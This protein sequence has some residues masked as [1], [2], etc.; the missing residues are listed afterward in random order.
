M[1]M[2]VPIQRAAIG[3]DTLPTV[4]ARDLYA[5]LKVSRDFSTWIKDRIEK[6][7]FI[8]HEDYVTSEGLSSPNPGSAKARAQRTIDYHLTL[9]MAKELS[10][11]ENNAQGRKARRYFIDVERRAQ[12]PATPARKPFPS[13]LTP[14]QFRAEQQR[15]AREQT[16]LMATPVVLSPD[17]YIY[18][19]TAAEM[20]RLSSGPTR[21]PPLSD[22]EKRQA[23]EWVLEHGLSK[24][25]AARRLGCTP[26]SIGRALDWATRIEG[27]EAA[28]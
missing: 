16:R 6:Y 23:A 25:E 4:N 21:R 8:E 3:R 2:I 12:Q 28:R 20:H 24:S 17:Q 9:D 10:M 19:S 14:A 27:Q 18:L 15:L 13:R 5:Y 7:G 26:R 1:S 22:A 11:V